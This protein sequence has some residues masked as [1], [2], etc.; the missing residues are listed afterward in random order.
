M[1]AI[2]Q[3]RPMKGPAP[4]PSPSEPVMK[5]RPAAA[6]APAPPASKKRKVVK[7]PEVVDSSDEASRVENR[8]YIDAFQSKM[9]CHSPF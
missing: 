8:P 6:P 2:V 9:T 3:F 5:K 1:P 4:E 7:T